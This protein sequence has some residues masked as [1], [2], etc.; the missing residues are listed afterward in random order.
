MNERQESGGE[1]QKCMTGESERERKRKRE[2]AQSLKEDKWV[3]GDPH[4]ESLC[5]VCVC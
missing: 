3:Q 2:W 4:P 5:C 1:R